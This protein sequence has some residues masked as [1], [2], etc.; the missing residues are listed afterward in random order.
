ML[1]AS[2]LMLSQLPFEPIPA[3]RIA[4]PLALMVETTPAEPEEPAPEPEQAQAGKPGKAGSI[5]IPS[6][7]HLWQGR[8]A[9]AVFLPPGKT[10][11][12]MQDFGV[13]SGENWVK[14]QRS[15][16]KAEAVPSIVEV[17]QPAYASPTDSGGKLTPYVFPQAS[18][19]TLGVVPFAA[20]PAGRPTAAQTWANL[21]AMTYGNQAG[22]CAS[23]SCGSSMAGR[24]R[25]LLGRRR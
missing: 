11:P 17:P 20:F 2:L 25:G 22:A 19:P 24:G 18:Q 13:V 12:G 3:L 10:A 7:W 14:I 5:E 8:S 4:A 15:A 21:P 9:G 1:L 16:T 6:G 23:G